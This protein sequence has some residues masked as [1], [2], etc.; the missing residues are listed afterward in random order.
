M[1][2]QVINFDKLLLEKAK[3]RKEYSNKIP[4]RYI[5]IED[6]LYEKEAEKILAEFPTRDSNWVDAQGLHTN[7]KWTQ[8]CVSGSVAD[9]FYQEVNSP[10]FLQ[11]LS[12][13][14][15]INQLLEDKD[16]SGA[17]YHQTYNGGFLNVHIDFN[18]YNDLDR[19]LNLL[20]YLNKNWQ[21]D[22]G[23][24]L[25][26]WNMEKKDRI[27]NIAPSFN[28]CVIFETNEISYHG[29]PVPLKLP[30]GSR[31]SL[32]VYYYTKGRDDIAAVDYHNT[33]Y[34]NT[35]GTKGAVRI[36]ANGIVHAIRKMYKTLK[37]STAN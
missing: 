30:E 17:G 37:N 5:I 34:V 18:K 10:Q 13:I 26:L 4:F 21:D 11:Y 28:R 12:D 19:R 9:T 1:H 35:N 16:L 29:H 31:K 32:S 25:E 20:V 15:G 2:M 22:Y 6:F 23:G 27:E 24:H 14:T 3:N 7:K 36:F 8:P 33:V